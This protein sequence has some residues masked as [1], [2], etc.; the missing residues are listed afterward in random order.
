MERQVLCSGCGQVVPESAVY[1]IP[2]FN[3]YAGGYV[4]TYRCEQCWE[5]SLEDTRTRLADTE[6]ETEI[7]SAAA[8]FERHNVFVHEYLR[9]DPAPIVRKRLGQLLDLL[10]SGAVRLKIGPD[11]PG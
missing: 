9:G 10:R 6:D 11:E 1:V 3:D 8:F 2:F 7:A 4:T 5:S